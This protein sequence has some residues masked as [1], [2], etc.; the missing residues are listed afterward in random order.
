MK[1]LNLDNGNPYK[2]WDEEDIIEHWDEIELLW[3]VLVQA[4][5]DETREEVHAE[6]APCTEQEFLIEYLKRSPYDLIIG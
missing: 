2:D 1:Y 5:D 6:L 3:D 4:M